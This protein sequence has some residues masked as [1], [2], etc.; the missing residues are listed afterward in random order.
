[1]CPQTPYY[2]AYTDP[3]KDV[4]VSRFMHISGAFERGET[5]VRGTGACLREELL[6]GERACAPA[7]LFLAAFS[8]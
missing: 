7:W 4:D 5:R 1:M 2:F 6:R 8:I 3:A